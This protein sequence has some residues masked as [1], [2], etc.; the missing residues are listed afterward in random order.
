MEFMW[1]VDENEGLTK[2]DGFDK[3]CKYIHSE[4]NGQFSALIPLAHILAFCD[5]YDK[6]MYDAKHEILLH[7][8][9]DDDALFRK[10]EKVFEADNAE[11]SRSW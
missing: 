7:R 4:E 3:R 5:N 6:V 9:D 10:P 2:N 11:H 1:S 8:T